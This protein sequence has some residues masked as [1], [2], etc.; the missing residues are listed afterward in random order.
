LWFLSFSIFC[1]FSHL[2]C[3]LSHIFDRVVGFVVLKFFVFM[4]VIF[5]HMQRIVNIACKLI[6]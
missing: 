4:L 6:P 1:E 3:V 5:E 2:M